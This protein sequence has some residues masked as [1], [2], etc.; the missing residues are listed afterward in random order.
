[1]ASRLRSAASVGART[2]AALAW[3]LAAAP[4]RRAEVPVVSGGGPVPR[5]PLRVLVW[6][7]QF[8]AGRGLRFFYDGGPDVVVPRTTVLRT[9][10]R[11]AEV[12]R[13]ADAD[14]V[15]LQEVDRD[16]ARTG[17]IDQ[18]EELLARVP[19]PSS[20]STPYFRNPYVPHPPHRHLGRVDMHLSVFARHRLDGAVRWALPDLHESWLRRQFNLRRA[21]LEVELP[22]EGGGRMRAFDLH[23]SAFSRGDGTLARQLAVVASRLDECDRDGVPFL[24]G[25]D[26]N[27]LP[28]GDDPARLPDP[29]LYA[30]GWPIAPLFERWTSAVPLA[31]HRAEPSGWRTWLPHGADVADRAIDHLFSSRT[32]QFSDVRVL[33]EA[34]DA[35]D[36]LPLVATFTVP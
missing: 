11:V 4:P 12:I 25:G 33:G 21:L 2:V 29:E 18:H 14:L 20:C 30:D 34:A 35:S 6:N 28:P 7:V 22:V 27:A 32:V 1:M 13:A 36:H 9:L 16:S 26:F 17:R 8:A 3:S 31:A 5:G 15:L 23:L 24:L 10:D 19:Y